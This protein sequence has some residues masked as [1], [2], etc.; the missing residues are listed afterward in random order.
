MVHTRREFPM[1]APLLPQ[2][3]TE[4]FEAAIQLSNRRVH[5]RFLEV[6]DALLALNMPVPALLVAGVILDSILAFRRDQGMHEGR[7]QMEL[8]S[9]LRNAVAH[10]HEP[11]VSLDQAREMVEVVRRSLMGEGG[12]GP[13]R[14]AESNP[15]VAAQQVRGKYQLVPT[16]SAE[17]IARKADELRLEHDGRGN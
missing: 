11:T 7:Q 3:V 4:H 14:P 15:A 2:D 16:S 13:H 1:A 5:L 6:A 10:A 12:I 17:F 8:W 9:E